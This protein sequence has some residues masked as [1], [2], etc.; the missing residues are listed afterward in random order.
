MQ[1]EKHHIRHLKT[2]AH[3]RKPI[4]MV[5]QRGLSDNIRKE[6]DIALEKHE[7]VKIKVS[8]GDRDA[9]DEAIDTLCRNSGA[10]MVQKIG[11][12]AV[13]FLRNQKKPII[14]FPA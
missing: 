13:L 14:V 2:I 8:V 6:L 3:S 10:T 4:V 5:G 11:N 12:I 7:L 1:L 9:R